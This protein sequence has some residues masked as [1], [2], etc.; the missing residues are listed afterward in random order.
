MAETRTREEAAEMPDMCSS[1]CLQILREVLRLHVLTVY[2]DPQS[3]LPGTM[4]GP[5]MVLAR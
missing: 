1:I 5:S 4:R 2:E 3:L